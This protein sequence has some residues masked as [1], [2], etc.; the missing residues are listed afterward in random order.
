MPLCSRV[1]SWI[2]CGNFPYQLRR[3]RVIDWK[4]LIVMLLVV[5]W[6]RR[7]SIVSMTTF[8]D[9]IGT[10]SL[11]SPAVSKSKIAG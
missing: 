6:V 3:S 11:I 4:E 2:I 8:T 1:P 7:I 9:S 10:I 5:R